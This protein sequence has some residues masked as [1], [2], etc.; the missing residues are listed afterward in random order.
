MRLVSW[1]YGDVGLDRWM[2]Q[3]VPHVNMT[4]FCLLIRV[5]DAQLSCDSSKSV[6]ITISSFLNRLPTV[7]NIRH[8]C[9]AVWHFS[10]FKLGF[11]VPLP[12]ILLSPATLSCINGA[13]WWSPIATK[14][15]IPYA[16]PLDLHLVS[17]WVVTLSCSLQLPSLV[18]MD[19]CDDRQLQQK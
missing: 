11:L 4:F 15:R 7:S 9:L 19:R 12:W 10:S 3:V 18:S 13:L 14:T 5:C 8:P 6:G 17:L 16:I 2:K 1:P